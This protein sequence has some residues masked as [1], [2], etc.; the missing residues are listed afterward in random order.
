LILGFWTLNFLCGYQAKIEKE[1]AQE[2]IPVKVF[3]IE[4]RDL[5]EV[6]EYVGNIKAFILPVEEIT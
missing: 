5:N 2:A 6:L 4:L 3:R 1:K